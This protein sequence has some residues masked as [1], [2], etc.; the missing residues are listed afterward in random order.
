[1]IMIIIYVENPQWCKGQNKF[2][3]TLKM[4]TCAN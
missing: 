4:L 3:T 2:S 1:M